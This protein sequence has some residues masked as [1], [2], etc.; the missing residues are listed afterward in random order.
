MVCFLV[1]ALLKAHVIQ[2]VVLVLPCPHFK[3]GSTARTLIKQVLESY[4]LSTITP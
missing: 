2:I 1:A 3:V 4:V